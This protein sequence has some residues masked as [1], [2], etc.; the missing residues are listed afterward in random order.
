VQASIVASIRAFTAS[1]NPPPPSGM[2]PLRFVAG[3]KLARPTGSSKLSFAARRQPRRAAEPPIS[4]RDGE[5]FAVPL[6]AQAPDEI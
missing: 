1:M 4:R 3:L 5:N 2:M 6:P